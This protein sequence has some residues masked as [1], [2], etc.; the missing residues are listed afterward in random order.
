[1]KKE[2]LEYACA[3]YGTP[4]YVFDLDILEA[5]AGRMRQA[6]GG[7]I[8]LCYAMKANPFLAER[9]AKIVDRIEVCSMGEFEICRT[10]EI[11]PEKLLISGVLK[12]KEDLLTILEYCGG[13]SRYTVESVRQFHQFMDWSDARGEE[14]RLYLRLTSGN[15]FGMDEMTVKN[16]I[17]VA[18]MSPYLKIEGIHYFSGTQKRNVKQ[19][20]KELTYL[21]DFMRRLK[22]EI[23]AEI[24]ELE[25]GSGT[26][27]PYFRG[28][29][30]QT[31]SEEG[32]NELGRMLRGMEW[33]GHITVEA[34]RVLTAMCGYYLTE[35]CDVKQTKG[36][37]YCIVD[38]GSHQLNYDGQIKGMYE[39]YV[40]V[41]PESTHPEEK[42]WTVCGALCTVND[43]LCRDLTLSGVRTGKVL[44]FERTGAYSC[45]E[46]MSLFLSHAL[47]EVLLYSE[48]EG[49]RK[50]REKTETYPM[51]M[52]DG[53]ISVNLGSHENNK[54]EDR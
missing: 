6:L 21:D 26:A 40:S 24:R 11:P 4:A 39:P 22:K 36:V 53:L 49:W 10:L 27:V 37:N 32:L 12:R 15:Q 19:L 25:Y 34:G 3:R 33:D 17:G 18:N 14:L 29:D 48:A 7:D 52:V 13:R 51:N 31:Y 28:K 38:G 8:S 30:A 5:E 50:V 2:K 23:H 44:I 46:G 42:K 47:P 20:E 45:M 54:M 16:I 9:M 35:I 1:M 43:V 41:I